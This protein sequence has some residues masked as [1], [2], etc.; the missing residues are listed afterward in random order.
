MTEFAIVLPL[1]LVLMLAVGYFGHAII[2]LQNLNAAARSAARLMALAST[3]TPDRRMRGSYDATSEQFLSLARTQLENTVRPEQLTMR[4]ETRLGHDY[5]SVLQLEGEFSRLSNH[6]FAYVLQESVDAT[7]F[8]Y[9]NPVPED[10]EGNLPA[11]LQNLRFGIGSVFYGGTLQYS[12]DELTPISRF[13]FRMR[14]EPAIKMGATALMPA[15]MPLRG[16]GYGLITVNPW[17]SELIGASVA[18]NSD[19]PDLITD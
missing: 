11:N 19:Y 5:N 10:R 15:E 6:R 2:S 3:E 16:A 1:L 9:N 17:L 8:Q 14:D 13:L 18:D 4:S 12:L 7:S